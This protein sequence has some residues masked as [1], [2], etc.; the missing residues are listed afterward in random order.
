MLVLFVS[1]AYPF[2]N[3]R[4]V[5]VRLAPGAFKARYRCLGLVHGVNTRPLVCHSPSACSAVAREARFFVELV[6]MVD[7]LFA[8]FS[9][10]N[11]SPA[12]SG[13]VLEAKIV[14]FLV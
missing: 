10:G 14:V 6:I 2:F 5:T 7:F 13:A 9:P 3:N 12:G 1:L 11:L 4:I 8:H